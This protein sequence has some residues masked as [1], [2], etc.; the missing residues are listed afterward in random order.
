MPRLQQHLFE[1]AQATRAAAVGLTRTLLAG[2]TASAAGADA[3]AT[4]MHAPSKPPAAAAPAD[5][6]VAVVRKL[7][8]GSKPLMC[9]WETRDV[10]VAAGTLT[11]AS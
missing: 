2:T 10:D 4:S 7:L 9:M 5:M 3:P 6:A 1:V 8:E 11:C